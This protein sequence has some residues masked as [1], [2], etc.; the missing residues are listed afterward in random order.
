MPLIPVE[1]IIVDA[2]ITGRWGLSLVA[3]VGKEYWFLKT[4][5]P[6]E[7]QGSCG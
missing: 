6:G 7:L 3:G 5:G 2:V 4:S 1:Y